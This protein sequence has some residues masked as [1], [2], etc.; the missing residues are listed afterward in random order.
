MIGSFFR[1]GERKANSVANE[2]RTAV[3]RLFLN[4]SKEVYFL[5]FLIRRDTR[6]ENHRFQILKSEN[7]QNSEDTIN[8]ENWTDGD[9]TSSNKTVDDLLKPLGEELNE[10]NGYEKGST[11]KGFDIEE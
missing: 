1:T 2:K 6:H 9:G 4:F 10:V 7:I 3:D 5:C 11:E 8:V